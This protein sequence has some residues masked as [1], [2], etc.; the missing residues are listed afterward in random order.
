MQ[1]LAICFA[2]SITW[3]N[4]LKQNLFAFSLLQTHSAWSIYILNVDYVADYAYRQRDYVENAGLTAV[5]VHVENG[6]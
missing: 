3:L 4:I 5:R 1:K 2:K 6:A